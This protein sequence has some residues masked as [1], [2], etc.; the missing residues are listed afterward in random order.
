M[1]ISKPQIVGILSDLV[2]KLMFL[3]NIPKPVSFSHFLFDGPDQCYPEK[4]ML[5]QTFWNKTF[6]VNIGI[7]YCKKG[8]D[9]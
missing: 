9:I 6:W 2:P 7:C 5:I 4:R 1:F 8:H 3:L